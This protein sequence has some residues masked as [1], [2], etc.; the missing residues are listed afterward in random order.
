MKVY[1]SADLEGVAGVTH[2]EHTAR[3]G[4]EHE[5]ARALMTDEINAAVTGAIEAGATE[6]VV[7]DSHG[8]MRN[9]IPEK[10]HK[11]AYLISGAPK[12]L[13][14]ME[15]I[16]S[17]FDAA[18]FLGYH[19]ACGTPDAVLDHTYAG[20][21]VARVVINGMEL[22]ETGINAA[23]AGHFGVPLVLV[24][25]DTA[26]ARQARE[27]VP[28][29]VTVAVKEAIGRYAAR[30]LH[31]ERAQALIREA[32]R[33]ALADL[34]SIG[35]FEIRPPIRLEL[36]LNQTGMADMAELVPGME[37]TG[38]RSVGFTADNYLSVFKAMRVAIALAGETAQ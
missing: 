25:G 23:V 27:L 16:D 13:S 20:R 38:P 35:C 5:R 15:G 7:N 26:V 1:I 3:D 8:T 10:L 37:R 11:D 19:A 12:P 28:R 14:M 4:K 24:T 31:P 18:M 6:V 22:G 30:S 33:K 34:R 29:V 17:T 32:A 2:S 21:T 9:I 36:H